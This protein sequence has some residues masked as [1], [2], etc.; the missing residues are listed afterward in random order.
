MPLE[1]YTGTGNVKGE[2]HGVM[3]PPPAQLRRRSETV[4]GRDPSLEEGRSFSIRRGEVSGE[5]T[6]RYR[7]NDRDIMKHRTGRSLPRTLFPSP[8]LSPLYAIPPRCA[9]IRARHSTRFLTPHHP[10][11]RRRLAP[12]AQKSQAVTQIN[13]YHITGYVHTLRRWR[14]SMCISSCSSPLAGRRI[15]RRYH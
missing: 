14:F 10:P 2:Q 6:K 1:I 8:Q 13:G 11:P 12:R 5:K 3:P 7:D 4:G 15:F 9:Y